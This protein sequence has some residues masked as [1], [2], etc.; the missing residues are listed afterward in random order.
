MRAGWRRVQDERTWKTGVIIGTQAFYL[1]NAGINYRDKQKAINE[2]SSGENVAWTQGALMRRGGYE[3]RA[4]ALNPSGA[5]ANASC[6]NILDHAYYK[7]GTTEKY[8][9]FVSVDAGG[10]SVA[11]QVIVFHADGIPATASA[12]TALGTA[13]DMP[14]T[15]AEAFDIAAKFSK[16]YIATDDND[17][18]V[19]YY[20][21]AWKVQEL[22]LCDTGNTGSNG[23][24]AGDNIIV[25]AEW[26]GCK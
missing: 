6:L 21:T 16:V 17:P 25:A 1:Y 18:Y 7:Y 4:S 24:S 8:F 19:L 22:P 12:F 9:L 23:Y 15:T 10:G 2:L 14:W 20:D 3:L 26:L 5:F 11:D 13:Y